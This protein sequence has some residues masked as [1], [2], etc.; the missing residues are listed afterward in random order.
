MQ[1]FPAESGSSE[2]AKGSPC[3]RQ[4]S[5]AAFVVLPMSKQTPVLLQYP[6]SYQAQ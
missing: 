6:S 2:P 3:A 5:S 1:P 4:R